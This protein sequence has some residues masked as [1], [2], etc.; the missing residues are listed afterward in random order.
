MILKFPIVSIADIT[1]TSS[2]KESHMGTDYIELSRIQINVCV[3][4]PLLRELYIFQYKTRDGNLDNG[5]GFILNCTLLARSPD[6]PQRIEDRVC[7][8]L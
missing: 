2:D 5:V 4:S 6:Y 1:T 3:S 8:S 7:L